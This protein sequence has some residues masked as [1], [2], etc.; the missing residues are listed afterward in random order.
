MD[1]T[2]ELLDS[3]SSTRKRYFQSQ[4]ERERERERSLAKEK[5]SKDC[6]L[7]ELNEEIS[8]LNTETALLKLAI[9]DLQK[10]SDKALLNGQKKQF[11]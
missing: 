11:C 5:S 9:S 4:R 1:I 10:T 6:Q 2:R 8:K 3:V 7:A